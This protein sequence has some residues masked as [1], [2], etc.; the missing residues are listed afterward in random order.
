MPPCWRVLTRVEGVIANYSYMEATVAI[1]RGQEILAEEPLAP[2]PV[3]LSDLHDNTRF[4][5]SN[6]PHNGQGAVTNMYND[7]SPQK[8]NQLNQLYNAQPAHGLLTQVATNAFLDEEKIQGHDFKVLRVYDTISRVNHSCRPN[9]A[10]AYDPAR[11]MGTLQALMD[12][13]QE[14]EI[15]INYRADEQFTFANRAIR[16]QELQQAYHFTCQCPVFS[17]TGNAPRPDRDARGDGRQ[18]FDQISPAYPVFIND[19]QKNTH[20]IQRLRGATEYVRLLRELQIA[21]GKLAWAYGKVA[22]LHI[23]IWTLL[24]TLQVT[25]NHC[26]HCK[27]NPQGRRVAHMTA[28]QTALST[29][30]TIHIGLYGTEHQGIKGDEQHIRDIAELALES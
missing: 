7:L 29:K 26:I 28:A 4:L 30:L 12:I 19:Q 16:R 1:R 27:A 2:L 14:E 6:V 18:R 10:L 9:A 24:E 11:T 5:V 21:D 13:A 17:L 15:F 23:D 22:E 25:G 3:S 20:L 8:Q